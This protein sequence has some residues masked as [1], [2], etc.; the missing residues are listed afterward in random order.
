MITLTFENFKDKPIKV[1]SI[2]D[3]SLRARP[4]KNSR[5]KHLVLV[6]FFVWIIW[7]GP[8]WGSGLIQTVVS[9]YDRFFFGFPW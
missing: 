5:S 6:N 8:V 1:K 7:N 9:G 2:H 3:V 4:V